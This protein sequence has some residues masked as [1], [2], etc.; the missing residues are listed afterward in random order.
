MSA[1]IEGWQKP[2]TAKRKWN[3]WLFGSG[4]IIMFEG[5]P[6]RIFN[7]TSS[8]VDDLLGMLNGAYN[9]AYLKGVSDC[10]QSLQ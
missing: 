4:Y 1:V 10:K 8:E 3:H 2:Y 5:D 9:I 6:L 7:G